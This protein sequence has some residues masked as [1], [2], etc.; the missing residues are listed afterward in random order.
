MDDQPVVSLGRTK[1]RVD[2]LTRGLKA[3]SVQK[4]SV[5]LTKTN[6]FV[7]SVTSRTTKST[8]WLP[9]TLRRESW[10]FRWYSRLQLRY[11][12]IRKL[13]SPYW[14]YPGRAGQSGQS[15]TFVAP[16][17]MGYLGIIENWPKRN[18]KGLKP[19]QLQAF[20]AKKKVALEDWTWLCGW[21]YPF[22]TRQ[23]FRAMRLN[24]LR[25]HT[26]RGGALHLGDRWIQRHNARSGIAREYCHSTIRWW[27]GVGG[28]AVAAAVA[29]TTVVV[30]TVATVTA[31]TET[32]AVVTSNT[33]SK[34][35]V[36]LENRN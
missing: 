23:K 24:W 25:I 12:K 1:R 19:Q 17:E 3:V 36:T 26:W 15:I 5:T 20:Q 33:K 28:K 16:N 9:R 4:V 34:K 27:R 10:H 29:I 7:L 32:V 35:A 31:M 6:V 14:T 22:L 11:H 18:M 8:I 2:E 21:S 13:C 30:D